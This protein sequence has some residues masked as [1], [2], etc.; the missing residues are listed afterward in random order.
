MHHT[1]KPKHFQWTVKCHLQFN[2][3]LDLTTEMEQR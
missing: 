1:I 3:S 2:D